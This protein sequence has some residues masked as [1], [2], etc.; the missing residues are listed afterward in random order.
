MASALHLVT[1]VSRSYL[2]QALLQGSTSPRNAPNAKRISGGAFGDRATDSGHSVKTLGA[3]FGLGFL[4]CEA[5]RV[6]LGPDHGF[7]AAHLRFDA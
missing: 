7:P 2:V 4:V 6:Q 1:V 5:P 3:Y